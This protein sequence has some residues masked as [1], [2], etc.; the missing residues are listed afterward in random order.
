MQACVGSEPAVSG[1]ADAGGADTSLGADSAFPGAD[2]STSG[3]AGGSSSDAANDSPADVA[4]AARCNP[5]ATFGVPIPLTELNVAGADSEYA[6]LTPDELT[7]YFDLGTNGGGGAT[8]LIYSAARGSQD[9]SFAAPALVSGVNTTA[10]QR[11]P[12]VT[13]DGLF[14]YAFTGVSTSYQISVATRANTIAQ[15]GA[16]SAIAGVNNAP[17]NA[18][19][20]VL[21]DN[22][23]LYFFS[24][25]SGGAGGFDMYRS[26]RVSGTFQTPV[27]LAGTLIN[28]AVDE[29][30]PIV[31]PDELTLY[32]GSS[33]GGGLG[34][35]D[36]YVSRRASTN[37]TWGTPVNVS[38]LNTPATDFP[39]WI[40]ADSCVLYFTSERVPDG[41]TGPNYAMYRAGRGQ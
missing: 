4:D 1:G 34:S 28:T 41:G 27:A 5:T 7:V 16:L 32:F 23:A 40:S 38:E 2:T 6:R 24:D 18:G 29:L 33:R 35:Y 10:L 12:S 31:T 30:A 36:M 13:Q 8:F 15:F 39:T 3:D 14:L 37:D 17:D 9:A 20:Y 25:R 26:A 19:D 22:S 11:A 21:P